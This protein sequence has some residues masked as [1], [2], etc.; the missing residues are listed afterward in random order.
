MQFS[1]SQLQ[2]KNADKKLLASAYGDQLFFEKVESQ[3]SEFHSKIDS[4]EIISRYIDNWL[5]DKI[6]YHEARKKTEHKADIKELVNDYETSL[7]IHQLEEDYIQRALN[8]NVDSSEIAAYFDLH[9]EAF[10]PE[11]DVV[12]F[13]M[14]SVGKEFDNDT[15]LTLWETEDLPVLQQYV[16]D[17]GGLMI[18]DPDKWYT[19][20]DMEAV[21][22]ENLYQKIRFKS[23][24]DYSFSE[25]DKRY[26]VKILEI[27][28]E[29][30]TPPFTYYRHKIR[31]LILRSR[32][33]LLLKEM[34]NN[35]FKEKI[36]S[37]NIK[38]YRSESK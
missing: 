6:L 25:D 19:K 4:E 20:S 5:M 14:I 34:K 3:L 8:V 23:P 32:S 1:C 31:E 9:Q 26:F 17:V 11:E 2:D 30:E 37:K 15:L 36:K 33:Q 13:M 35:I 16:L 38:I 10:L 24:E 12:R 18:I 28:K 7:Y 22:P 21:L 29:S 27:I